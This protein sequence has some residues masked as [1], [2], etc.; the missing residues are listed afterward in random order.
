MTAEHHHHEEKRWPQLQTHLED[1]H[2]CRDLP[3]GDEVQLERIHKDHHALVPLVFVPTHVV[4]K[5][6]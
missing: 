3:R 2:G 1:D 6:D 5:G 4:M